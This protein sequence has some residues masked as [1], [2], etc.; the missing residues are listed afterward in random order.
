MAVMFQ[1]EIL[2]SCGTTTLHG[3]TIQ[4]TSTWF[5][6]AKARLDPLKVHYRLDGKRNKFTFL[7]HVGTF[8]HDK[9]T[10]PQCYIQSLVY[11]QRSPTILNAMSV[12]FLLRLFND[13]SSAAWFKWRTKQGKWSWMVTN[14]PGRQRSWHIWRY[15]SGIHIESLMTTT[16]DSCEDSG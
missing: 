13:A 5:I 9:S 16:K 11:S 10:H 1:V 14:G 4:K 8:P 2:W 6:Y 3:V 15:N 7:C 12:Y